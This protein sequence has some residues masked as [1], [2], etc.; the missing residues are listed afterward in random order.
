MYPDAEQRMEQLFAENPLMA[1]EFERHGKLRD[2][3]RVT[4]VGRWLRKTSMD[5]L[6]QLWNVLKGEMSLVGPR[7]YLVSQ[8]PQMN[9]NSEII[10]RATPGM[11]GLW[12]VSG[13]SEM[14]FEQRV[15]LDMYY[16]R[17]WSVWLDLVILAR[18][19]RCALFRRD[20]AY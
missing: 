16:V 8:V 4:E 9:G 13:R 12:Q 17:N 15:D 2:D 14:A 19:V 7:P 5:E 1:K 6:P 3:P 20:G 10:W 11:S 18:T